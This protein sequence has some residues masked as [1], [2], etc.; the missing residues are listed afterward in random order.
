MELKEKEKKILE[1]LRLNP[2]GLNMSKVSKES[3]LKVSFVR[4]AL[5]KL[6]GLGKVY[7][8]QVGMSKLYKL[9]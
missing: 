4:T 8:V 3:S 1:T 2:D 9:K 7:F 5:Y 6:E